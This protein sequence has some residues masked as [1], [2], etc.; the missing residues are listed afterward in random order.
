MRGSFQHQQRRVARSRTN[1]PIRQHG[2]NHSRGRRPDRSPIHPRNCQSRN[3]LSS[4]SIIHFGQRNGRIHPDWRPANR[5]AALPAMQKLGH[6]AGP[7][8]GASPEPEGTD[9]GFHLFGVLGRFVTLFFSRLGTVGRYIPLVQAAITL[10]RWALRL[11]S[12]SGIT[13]YSWIRPCQS[14][15]AASG[16]GRFP[17]QR[18]LSW[19]PGRSSTYAAGRCR[20]SGRA[21]PP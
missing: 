2:S 4:R 11:F 6:H 7:R 18:T 8:T 17:P 3:S 19:P 9:A 15:S 1:C 14:G 21:A 20:N 13:R 10:D 16:P 12:G 5:P